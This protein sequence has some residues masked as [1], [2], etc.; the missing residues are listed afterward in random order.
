MTDREE[1]M[2]EIALREH[3]RAAIKVVK[4]RRSAVV[5]PMLAEEKELR[6]FIRRLIKEA[7]PAVADEPVHAN[8][9]INALEDLFKNS[10]LLT[11]LRQG[12]KSLTSRKEQRES[13]K[14]HILNAVDSAL[15][16]EDSIYNADHPALQE[17]VNISVE[18]D[19]VDPAFID[20]EKKEPTEEDEVDAFAIT[21]QDKTGRNRAYT[22]FKNIDKNLIT[23]FDN[24]DD[25]DDR[26]MFKD[27]LMTN[28]NL[29]FERFE[30]ELPADLPA[31]EIETPDDAE[32]ATGEEV[33]LDTE[34]IVEWLASH[35]T[36]N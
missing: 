31:P 20:V 30:E 4:A 21:G 15:E 8:T 22:G 3:I 12:Y 13:Y 28:L 9:G 35:V 26:A 23:A 16:T 14:N 33:A 24:L 34:E 29:Y 6:S 17:D 7:S 1:F 32:I 19:E 2:E 36:K 25:P 10:N 18:E 5:P 11:V 27:Y